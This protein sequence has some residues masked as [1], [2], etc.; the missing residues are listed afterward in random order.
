MIPSSTPLSSTTT[1]L[2]NPAFTY[3]KSWR[4]MAAELQWGLILGACLGFAVLGALS[5]GFTWWPAATNRLVAQ[6]YT[7]APR[8]DGMGWVGYALSAGMLVVGVIWGIVWRRR[9]RRR[10]Q[11]QFKL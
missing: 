4:K 6:V 8:Q 1:T 7:N 9:F 3:E 5:I 10:F 11:R 2:D